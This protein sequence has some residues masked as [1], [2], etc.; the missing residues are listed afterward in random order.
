M[1]KSIAVNAGSSTLK[2]KLFLCQKKRSYQ[3]APLIELGWDHPA[4]QSSMVMAK[5]LKILR[6][7]TTTNRRFS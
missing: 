5:S 6:I 1:G 7:S 2:Y 4:F 3:V